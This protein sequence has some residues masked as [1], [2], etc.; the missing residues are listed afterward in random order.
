MKGEMS[1]IQDKEAPGLYIHVPFCRSKCPYCA[2]FSIPAESL[3]PNWAKAIKT[4]L[5]LYKGQ[6]K[7][8][9]T[10]YVGGGTPS[11][12]KTE[13]LESII[14]HVFTHFDFAPHAEIT[15]EA[16]PRDLT[17]DKIQALKTMGFNRVSLGV[18]SLSDRTLAFL[19]RDHTAAQAEKAIENLRAA[20][21]ENIGIDLIYGFREQPLKNW[22]A[23]LKRA[24]SFQPE[25]LSCYQLTIEKRTPFYCLLDKQMLMPLSNK[26][27]QSYFLTTSR[28]L[29]KS[30]YIHYEIS[31][32]ARERK[33]YSKHN[34]K[35]WNHTPYLG[36]GPSAHSFYQQRRWWNVRSVRQYCEALAWGKRPVAASEDL[37]EEQLRFESIFLGLR[38][39][40]GVGEESLPYHESEGLLPMLRDSGFIRIDKGK[41]IPTRKGFLVADHLACRLSG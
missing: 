39:K 24:I 19:G 40:D 5:T 14:N 29:E 28:L 36:L 10:L 12:L 2:F 3:I 15:I 6:F 11:F 13:V 26:Q 32:F 30:S 37:S 34:C 22:I 16:N 33:F 41:V 27:E 38:T 35:Y 17:R 18:Q 31:S 25:H 9:D 21:F 8:F 23:T 7:T 20:G 1:N 4:E